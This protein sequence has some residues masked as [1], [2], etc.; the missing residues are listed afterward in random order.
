MKAKSLKCA[1]LALAV[2]VTSGCGTGN[3][4]ADAS[5]DSSDTS[6]ITSLTD[7]SFDNS[8]DTVAEFTGFAGEAVK[9][10]EDVDFSNGKTVVLSQDY[11]YARLS[12]GYFVTSEENPELFPGGIYAG[13]KTAEPFEALEN[14]SV[15][16]SSDY[17]RIYTGDS[18][19]GLTVSSAQCEYYLSLSQDNE[20][21]AYYRASSLA[22]SGT[23]TLS[24]VLIKDYG[25]GERAEDASYDLVF[26]P[27]PSLLLENDFPILKSSFVSEH[28]LSDGA[29]EFCGD[30]FGIALNSY[31]F[32]WEDKVFSDGTDYCYA[33]VE[34]DNIELFCLRDVP[35]D[36]YG[37][38][39]ARNIEREDDE[40]FSEERIESVR[41]SISKSVAFATV[42]ALKNTDYDYSQDGKSVDEILKI[43]LDRNVVCFYTFHSMGLVLNT[44]QDGSDDSVFKVRHYF[45]NDYPE[46]E[47]FVE[48]TYT[49]E[50]C[51]HL[52]NDFGGR[53]APF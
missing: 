5:L 40:E 16:A 37:K 12:D 39:A 43:L 46:L 11:T 35:D 13:D 53:G 23:I 1:L 42:A 10:P 27:Y 49:S 50:C 24:G 15:S 14:G 36:V 18:F 30:T 22:F 51:D 21:T 28:Y 47:S 4:F 45:F 29:F 33:S 34:L 17:K 8:T 31:T 38:A 2:A 7:V 48:N 20:L 25:K 9:I 6:V 52:L 26:Y 41:D 32:G 3:D 19:G 44:E